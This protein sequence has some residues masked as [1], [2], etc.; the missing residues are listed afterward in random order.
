MSHFHAYLYGHDVVVFTDHSAVHAVLET[1]SANGKHARWWSKLFGAGLKSIKI[2][3]RPGKDNPHADALSRSPMSHSQSAAV[4]DSRDYNPAA[5]VQ[6]AAVN[7]SNDVSQ[8]EQLLQAKP[9]STGSLVNFAAEQ[10]RDPYI[11]QIIQ[12]LSDGTLP[13][14]EQ[15]AKLVQ[16]RHHYLL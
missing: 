3:Y 15:Q 12:C 16:H 6:V 11:H 14:N 5:Q 10:S 4:S 13:P 1:P 7:T 2:V 8:I 9:V